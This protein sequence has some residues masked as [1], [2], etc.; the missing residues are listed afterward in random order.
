[1]I[2]V[3]CKY[4]V[5][6]LSSYRVVA[7]MKICKMRVSKIIE[8][9]LARFDTFRSFQTH[10]IIIRIER[11]EKTVIE[12]SNINGK[13]PASGFRTEPLYSR[14]IIRIHE[15]ANRQSNDSNMIYR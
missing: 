12:I 2:F 13:L 4:I 3:C 7:L 9:R 5:T 1:M 10:A 11:F 14:P 15:W 8:F 6:D